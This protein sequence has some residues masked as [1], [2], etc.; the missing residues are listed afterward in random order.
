MT[1]KEL[2]HN[3]KGLKEIKPNQEWAVLTK[4]RILAQAPSY[5][6]QDASVFSVFRYKLA[7]AP[8][9]GVLIVI[10][11]LGFAQSTRPG[12]FLFSI[13]KITETVQIGLSSQTEKPKAQLQLVNRR[14][15]ELSVLA[16][17]NQ[18]ERITP[19][20][21]E[22][23]ASLLQAAK[24]LAAIKNVTSSDQIVLKEIAEET[25][26]LSENKEKIETVLGTKIGDTEELENAM[27]SL[28]KKTAEYLIADLESRTLLE[29]QENILNEAKADIEAGDYQGALYK[30]WQIHNI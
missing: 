22:F 20:I 23:Q 18:T 30:L 7:L 6:S 5:Q 4:S 16:Q 27:E 17:G 3:L 9:L 28:E 21:E 14:L 25:K 24:D 29:E 26:K 15:E 8:M 13:K 11:L 10:G 1:E 12:D 19:A 2:I